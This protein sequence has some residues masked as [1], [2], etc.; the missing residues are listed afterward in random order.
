MI[1]KKEQYK[2]L[3]HRQA[4][5]FKSRK[6]I[7]F[8]EKG[9]IDDFEQVEVPATL[10]RNGNKMEAGEINLKERFYGK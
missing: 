7:T 6:A 3:L 2:K 1:L 5:L 8:P 9:L 10:A 4:D